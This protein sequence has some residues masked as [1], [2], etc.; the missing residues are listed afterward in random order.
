M[1]TLTYGYKSMP[2]SGGGPRFS[3]TTN[4]DGA[5]YSGLVANVLGELVRHGVRRIAFL[6]G[7][8]ENQW[9]LNEGIDGAVQRAQAPPLRVV[10]IEYWDVLPPDLLTAIFPEGLN[11][12][13]EHAAVMETSL[14]LHYFPDLVRTDR[15]PDEPTY[16][17]PPYDVF[18][19]D[20][21]W[22]P[23]GG[24]LSPA[25]GASADKGRRLADAVVSGVSEALCQAFPESPEGP[26]ARPG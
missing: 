5:T 17:Y 4:L 9:F 8:L 16:P 12:T 19:A 6:N 7:H 20:P 14:M 11:I 1:P 21:T 26:P 18:P 22:G 24:A 2:K 23:Q 25:V 3:G 10:R 15:I 13:Y